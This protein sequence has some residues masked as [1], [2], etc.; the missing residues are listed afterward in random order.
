MKK[1]IVISAISIRS[2][3]MLSILLDCLQELNDDEYAQY[4]I[5]VIVKDPELV[6]GVNS[7]V[8]YITIDGTR[9]YFQRLSNE[10]F[11]FQKLSEKLKPFLWLS[12]HDVSPRVFAER[13]AVYCHN[14]T[15]FYE[16]T[17]RELRLEPKFGLFNLFYS[18]LYRLNIKRNRYVIVQ[19]DWLRNVFHKLFK[20]PL[21]KI[22]VARPEVS[23]RLPANDIS[24][25]DIRRFIFPSLP[26]VW[27]NF[28]L[29]C[30]A[31]MKLVERGIKNFEVI[32]TVNGDECP[33]AKLLKNE[34]GHL[35]NLKFIGMQP[36]QTLFELYAGSDCLIF[37]SKLESWG[38]PISEFK[39]Y[40]KP[41][42]LADLPYTHEAVGDYAEVSFFDPASAE[43]LASLMERII[44]NDLSF[45]GN[46][47]G[48]IP[49][50]F[51]ASWKELFRILLK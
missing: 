46:K 48:T 35:A 4:E 17:W 37:P 44:E 32:L 24:T 27:K 39:L 7:K 51:A 1:R 23:L 40:R 2:G 49:Q 26:R 10:F 41:M 31:S 5:D 12:L 8:N 45:K 21:D 29:V 15:P 50:P 18:F 30:E 11:Y 9:S 6:S 19:Q 43:Q 13:Q 42:M 38:L 36:R 22:I 3:G 25:N 28:E 34:Y 33:Y 47:L 16:I 14:A 20:I